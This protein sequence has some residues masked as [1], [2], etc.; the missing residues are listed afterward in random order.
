[1]GRPTGVAEVE[2]EPITVEHLRALL[3]ALDAVCP[4]GLQ[5]PTGGSLHVDLLGSGGA[6]LATSRAASSTGRS[7]AGAPSTRG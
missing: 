1:M 7:V 6:L 4:G 3:T 2:G 5:A